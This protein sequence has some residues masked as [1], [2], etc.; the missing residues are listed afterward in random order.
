MR[1]IKGHDGINHVFVIDL[2]DHKIQL[3]MLSKLSS[4][5]EPDSE[6][7]PAVSHNIVFYLIKY[8]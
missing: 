4:E 5:Y 7:G 1:S 3:K 6:G 2:I 8:T